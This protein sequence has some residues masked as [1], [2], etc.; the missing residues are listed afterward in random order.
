[1]SSS[2]GWLR[3]W[4][5]RDLF[6]HFRLVSWPDCYSA[7]LY[8]SRPKLFESN[9]RSEDPCK[10]L[11]PRFRHTPNFVFSTCKNPI[12]SGYGSVRAS[13]RKG[14]ARALTILSIHCVGSL[15]PAA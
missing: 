12:S 14:T 3:S 1:M 5:G 13:R 10:N 6:E 9:F 7:M 11:A 4:H 2:I 15:R 8:M